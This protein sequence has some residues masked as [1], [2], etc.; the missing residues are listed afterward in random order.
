M[1]I[2]H[3]SDIHLGASMRTHLSIDKA[4]KRQEELLATFSRMVNFATTNNIDGVI[5]AGD[6]LDTG[7]CDIK[8]RNFLINTI[9]D[10]K[11]VEF[12]YLCGNYQHNNKKITA[13]QT[14]KK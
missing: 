9:A 12:Y 6:L 2:I 3:C 5:I 8:T 4:R 10:A 1:K 11:N 13:W 14:T 7:E